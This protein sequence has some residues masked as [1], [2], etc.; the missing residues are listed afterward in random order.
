M[1]LTTEELDECV[2]KV[3][4]NL[5]ARGKFDELRK[6]CMADV[7]RRPSY[8]KLQN[9]VESFVLDF[10]SNQHWSNRINKNQLR[11]RLRNDLE[12]SNMLKDGIES[13]IDQVVDDKIEKEFESSITTTLY[14]TLKLNDDDDLDQ[15]CI[16]A[17]MRSPNKTDK[18]Y[19]QIHK[20]LNKIDL[21]DEDSINAISNEES[22]KESMSFNEN[23]NIDSTIVSTDKTYNHL[24]NQSSSR[25]DNNDDLNMT[26]DD[27]R[28]NNE[29][30]AMEIV[31]PTPPT[32]EMLTPGPEQT[33]DSFCSSSIRDDHQDESDQ[34]KPTKVNGSQPNQTNNPN[35]VEIIEDLAISSKSETKTDDQ[36]ESLRKETEKIIQTSVYELT[37]SQEN[38]INDDDDSIDIYR[39]ISSIETCDLSSF[40]DEVS[41]DSDSESIKISCQ[42]IIEFRDDMKS[43]D[44]PSSS[45]RNEKSIIDE[46]S[47]NFEENPGQISQEK[48]QFVSKKYFLTIDRNG[49][50]SE[51]SS[52]S[53]KDN[54]Q[55]KHSETVKNK[56]KNKQIFKNSSRKPSR[57]SKETFIIKSSIKSLQ[58]D[59]SDSSLQ[60]E[61]NTGK[62]KK[63]FN[64]GVIKQSNRNERYDSSDLYKPRHRLQ[65]S[66]RSR[67][68]QQSTVHSGSNLLDDDADT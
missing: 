68:K 55:S 52:D 30:E 9:D 54:S 51:S 66:R 19:S 12:D 23:Q 33:M 59:G 62:R 24:D 22:S 42:T 65:S 43:L 5:K 11:N 14:D 61:E 7:D 28:D 48:S 63:S 37:K 8:K 35:T 27:D 25:L 2:Y 38:N 60:K 4:D 10:L 67:G 50:H 15:D 46:D 56:K 57:T 39:D 18:N 17:D 41:I 34:G 3:I 58:R 53:E 26:A 47:D 1:V 31:W 40:E 21:N 64:S 44:Q 49:S 20:N 13:L 45:N 29:N 16:K 6:E 32:A 36:N